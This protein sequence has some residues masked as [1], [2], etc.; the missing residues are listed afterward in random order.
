[1]IVWDRGRVRYLEGSAEEGVLRGKIDFELW[2]FKLRGRFALV[3]TGA[4]K[5]AH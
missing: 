5:Q 3:H 1:M 2:G 4:R